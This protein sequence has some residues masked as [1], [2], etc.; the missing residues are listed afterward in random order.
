MTTGREKTHAKIEARLNPFGQTLNTLRIK[1]E[2]RQDKFNGQMK[3]TLGDIEKQH[4]KA[5][6]RLQTMSSLTSADWLAAR[7]DVGK[8]LDDIDAGLRRAL[9]HYK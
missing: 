7:T 1:T 4:E 5:R 3:Q 6:Q 8:Y 9:A 2:P